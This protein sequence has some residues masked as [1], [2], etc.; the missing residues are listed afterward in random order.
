MSLDNPIVQ[1]LAPGSTSMVPIQEMVVSTVA[2]S[3]LSQRCPAC[4][5]GLAGTNAGFLMPDH[6]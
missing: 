3:T 5:I 2:P 4:T 6:I 1:D